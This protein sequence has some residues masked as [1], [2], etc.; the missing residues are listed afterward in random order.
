MAKPGCSG[1]VRKQCRPVQP[2]QLCTSLLLLGSLLSSQSGPPPPPSAGCGSLQ[3]ARE[4]ISSVWL[5]VNS[6][7]HKYLSPSYAALFC[8]LLHLFI[9]AW[10]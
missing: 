5:S 3:L 8:G 4:L 6:Y 7:L 9:F 10:Q 1:S 2:C